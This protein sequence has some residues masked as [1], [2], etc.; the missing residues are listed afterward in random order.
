MLAFE[1]ENGKLV[2]RNKILE[3]RNVELE[4]LLNSLDD[5]KQKNEYLKNKV[6]C[7]G[8]IENFLRK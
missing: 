4:L 6:K 3:T 5:L 1:E 7:N 8:K 2:V